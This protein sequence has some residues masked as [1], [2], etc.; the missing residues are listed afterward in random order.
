M[1]RPRIDLAPHGSAR[2]ARACP[3]RRRVLHLAALTLIAGAAAGRARAQE[4]ALP[5]SVKAAYLYKFLSY[6]EWPPAAFEGADSPIVIGVHG[7][8]DVLAELRQVLAGRTAQG[9]PLV[10]RRVAQGDTLAGVHVLFLGQANPADVESWLAPWRER[11]ILLVTDSGRG[12]GQGSMINFVLVGGR[13]RFE[14]SLPAAERSGLKLSSRM[15]Q[16]AERVVGVR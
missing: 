16:V 11:P 6:V 9:R 1:N 5:V 3:R 14:V 8:D 2:G 7:A 13:L 12:L 10:S 4:A 15:L